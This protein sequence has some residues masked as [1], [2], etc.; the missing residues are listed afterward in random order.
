MARKSLRSLST[1]EIC[2]S[3]W[4]GKINKQIR[5]T[6]ANFINVANCWES[7]IHLYN[8]LRLWS[9]A[10]RETLSVQY[11]TTNIWLEITKVGKWLLQRK[12]NIFGRV[13]YWTLLIFVWRKHKPFQ[14]ARTGVCGNQKGRATN[15]SILQFCLAFSHQCVYLSSVKRF[16]AIKCGVIQW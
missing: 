2:F 3:R 13:K 7:Y 5:H 15:K 10:N 4:L 14:F 11:W 16:E 9:A 8:P 6:R 1:V 12:W